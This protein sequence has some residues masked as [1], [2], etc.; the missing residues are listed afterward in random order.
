MNNTVEKFIN[1]I[2]EAS[3]KP[4]EK[5]PIKPEE[6]NYELSDKAKAVLLARPKTEAEKDKL[7]RLI[8]KYENEYEKLKALLNANTNK[9][10][11]LSN[12]KEELS[13]VIQ[14]NQLKYFTMIEK[15]C[16]DFLNVVKTTKRFLY[17]GMRGDE[18]VLLGYPHEKRLVKDTKEDIQELFDKMLMQAGFKALR[19]NSIFTTGNRIHA[20]GFGDYVYLIFPKDGYNF[21]WSPSHED[22][23]PNFIDIMGE[24]ENGITLIDI[25]YY[26]EYLADALF[27][28]NDEFRRF[29]NDSKKFKE[30][31][32]KKYPDVGV[33]YSDDLKKYKDEIEEI[34][35]K[36]DKDPLTYKLRDNARDVYKMLFNKQH[37]A[38]LSKEEWKKLIEVIKDL[39]TIETKYD[40]QFYHLIKEW[41]D[42]IDK[43]LAAENKHFEIKITKETAEKFIKK[44]NLKNDDMVRAL[45][46]T[47]EI[48]VN[49]EYIALRAL[50]FE[51]SANKYFLNGEVKTRPSQ[52]RD[53]WV[54]ETRPVKAPNQPSEMNVMNKKK[55][56][57]KNPGQKGPPLKK[58]KPKYL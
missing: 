29:M 31:I 22:W 37:P 48:Y 44:H 34:K 26:F 32:K 4:G 7:K 14:P 28:L 43:I 54:R 39:K 52:T 47:N 8:K 56:K 53:E 2:M 13:K 55:Q 46:S 45:N 17:R 19:S 20:R 33:I 58:S 9:R 3:V 6:I 30:W 40:Y 50:N 12:K 51:N 41:R 16:G 10:N 25:G 5:K 15:E 18:P 23:I 1:K 49:G 35:E 24:D 42:K 21:T 38:Q 27:D 11:M 57:S 36:M